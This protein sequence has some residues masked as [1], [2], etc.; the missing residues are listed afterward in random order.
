MSAKL[1][2]KLSSYWREALIISMFVIAIVTVVHSYQNK[3]RMTKI[4][5]LYNTLNDYGF[6]TKEQKAIL[7]NL[8]QQASILAPGESIQ[9]K[10]PNK[11]NYDDLV[12]D[13][14]EFV[15]LTQKYFTI[16]SGNQERWEI[17]PHEWMMKNKAEN[18]KLL[19]ILGMTLSVGPK[20]Q[21]VDALC[22]LGGKMS[23]MQGRIDYVALLLEK[24]LKAN[25]LILLSGERYVTVKIDGTQEELNKIAASY[26]LADSSKLTETHL[27]QKAY[28]ESTLHNKIPTYVIDTPARDLPRPTTQTTILEL[29]EWLKRHEEIKTITFVSNQPYVKYQEAV[30]K[31]AMRNFDTPI[32]IEVVGAAYNNDNVQPIIEALGSFIFAVTPDVLIKSGEKIK[33]PELINSFRELYAKQP[34]IYK[35]LEHNLFNKNDDKNL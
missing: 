15:K 10:F 4:Y 16:R 25:N 22:I 28:E 27:I 26:Q 8:M 3:Y 29:I 32:N 18:F 31:E 2:H 1:K 23:N 11:Y 21:N 9:A 24:G 6:S 30:I 5:S 12:V 33:D 34:L 19:K 13:I 20:F 17:K 7:E 35:N 14:L